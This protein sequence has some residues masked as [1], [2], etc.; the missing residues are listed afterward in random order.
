MIDRDL[1]DRSSCT[2]DNL[3]KVT[4][5]GPLGPKGCGPEK[6]PIGIA[7]GPAHDDRT[8]ATEG[9][10]ATAIGRPGP[11]AVQVILMDRANHTAKRNNVT[12]A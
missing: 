3:S 2:A 6:G 10:V 1:D 5:L 9:D 8:T 11:R 12:R 7:E 4:N